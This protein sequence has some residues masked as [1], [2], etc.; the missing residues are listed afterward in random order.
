M[1]DLIGLPWEDV[2]FDGRFI[3]GR[4]MWDLGLTTTKSKRICQVEKTSQLPC[5]LKQMKEV[6]ELE[7]CRLGKRIYIGCFVH[8]KGIGG[9]IGT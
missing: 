2:A 3:E 1:I 6:Q 9:M 4:R 5:W 7:L 8:R